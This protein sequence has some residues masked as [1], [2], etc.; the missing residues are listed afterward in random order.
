M[1]ASRSLALAA[2]VS[3]LVAGAAG[4]G[5]GESGKGGRTPSAGSAAPGSPPAPDAWIPGRVAKMSVAEKVGQLFVPTFSSRADALTK[6]RKY[7]VGGLIY[8][9]GNIGTPARTAAQ[10]NALQKASKIPLLLGV[11][12]EQGI[13][14][15]TPFVTT[16]PGNMALGATRS[17]ADARAAARV[18]GAELRA[19]GI[20]LDY[21]PDADVNVNPRNPVIGLRSFGSE[22]SLASTLVRGA[23]GGFQEAGV[24]AAAKHFPGHGDTATDSHTGLPVIR[25]SPR[26]W[27]LLDAPPFR[28]AIAADVDMIM[29]AHIVVPELDG[30]GDPSTLSKKVLTGLLRGRLGY[31]GVIT[32]D[33]LEMA[34]VREKYGD[35]GVPVRAINAGA[36]Q[37][38]MPPDLP[39]AYGAVMKAVETGKITRKRLDESVTRILRLKQRR[40]LFQRTAV[41]PA[42]AAAAVG[43]AANKAVARGVAE[44][45]VTLVRND[46]GLLPLK[47]KKVAV[48]GPSA[49][50]LQAALRRQ[51]VTVVAPGSADVMVLTTLNAGAATASRIRALGPKPVVVAALGRPYDLDSAG[52]AKAALATYSSSRVSVEALARV[53][54]GAVKPTGRL[55][56]PAGGKRAGYGTGY[57]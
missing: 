2:A 13:V 39:R 16:F 36:D 31:Q 14:S 56:V 6:I 33:S 48:S 22:P 54:G 53:L 28:A 4:C 29:T 19:V 57:R 20:N 27:E 8:F 24:A 30:S 7:R 47:G 37:L 35:A 10:S 44:H 49:D 1:R 25:H 5:G 51:G 21:A 12:E 50:R 46:G 55:P 3:A 32:T 26:T 45:A 42:K 9:P 11:D 52:G 41:D 43:T 23:I 40:G 17:P 34:G 18:T 15:R 38:L